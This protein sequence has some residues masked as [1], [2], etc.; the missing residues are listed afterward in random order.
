V[1]PGTDERFFPTTTPTIFE[2][3]VFI[4]IL[5]YTFRRGTIQ[6]EITR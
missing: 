2:V 4:S 5:Y 3:G 6:A 1:N